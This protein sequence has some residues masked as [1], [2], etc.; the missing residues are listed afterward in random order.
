VYLLIYNI[1]YKIYDY[2]S[3]G[4]FV[5]NSQKIT[6]QC[7]VYGYY[8]EESKPRSPCRVTQSEGLRS[9]R[10]HLAADDGNPGR[11]AFCGWSMTISRKNYKETGSVFYRLT[12][13]PVALSYHTHTRARTYIKDKR[14]LWCGISRFGQRDLAADLY[15][16]SEKRHKAP[17]TWPL[18]GSSS[19]SSPSSSFPRPSSKCVV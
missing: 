5:T 9:H 1:L 16:I 2:Y 7:A 12:C 17:T 10:V 18:Y 15:N 8:G 11:T 19:S 6:N 4:R 3:G 14:G 13:V